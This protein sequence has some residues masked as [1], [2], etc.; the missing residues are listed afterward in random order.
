[1]FQTF[2]Q[3][4]TRPSKLVELKD[5]KVPEYLIDVVAAFQ[6]LGHKRPIV[7]G[8][9][10][11]DIYLGREPRDIDVIVS[12]NRN[13]WVYPLEG[14][15]NSKLRGLEM[16]MRSIHI[17]ANRVVTFNNAAIGGVPCPIDFK[18][19]ATPLNIEDIALSVDVTFNA[20]AMDS[21]GRVYAHPFFEQD[22]QGQTYRP[23]FR[24]IV[25]AVRAPAR[26]RHFKEKF[27]DLS[28][29]F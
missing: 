14:I 22:A 9:A 29:A 4:K 24:D 1:M 15:E 8:G 11:R 12:W 5:F 10:L 26:F 17:F 28:F 3:R 20:V 16:E 19:V 7:H 27:P 21:D 13:E 23:I 25:S 18:V 2:Q 6:A